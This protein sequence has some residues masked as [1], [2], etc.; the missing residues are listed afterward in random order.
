M[1]RLGQR[2]LEVLRLVAGGM[3]NQDVASELVIGVGTVK[4]HLNS[5]YG[6]LDANS[7]TRAA[8]RAREL[9]LL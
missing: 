3:S 5:I 9:N 2:E 4:T 8:A 7:R 6:K 1:E